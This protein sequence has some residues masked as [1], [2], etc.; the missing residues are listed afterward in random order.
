MQ[1]LYNRR[2]RAAAMVTGHGHAELLSMQLL[3]ASGQHVACCLT[4][5]RVA[6]ACVFPR[7]AMAQ[8]Q[9]AG[10]VSNGAL[11]TTLGAAGRTWGCAGGIAPRRPARHHR[12]PASPASVMTRKKGATTAAKDVSVD[13]AGSNA[14][15]KGVGRS[16][17]L[18]D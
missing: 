18:S 8:F 12:Q 4:L 14:G 1:V 6:S 13:W 15:T 16:A 9:C 7:L 3:E 2:M 5:R 17:E 10:G 11:V